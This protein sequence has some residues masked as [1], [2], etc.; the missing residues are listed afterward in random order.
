MYTMFSKVYEQVEMPYRHKS[1]LQR[2]LLG[3]HHEEL[4]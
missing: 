2:H 4:G 1:S 3:K